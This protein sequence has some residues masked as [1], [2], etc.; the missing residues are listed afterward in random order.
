M[1]GI[2]NTRNASTPTPS[3][4]STRRIDMRRPMPSLSKRSITGSTRYAIR[5]AAASGVSAARSTKKSAS[6][7]A[8][9][10]R[11]VM[12]MRAARATK[13]RSA[14]A[15]D[16]SLAGGPGGNKPGGGPTREA[17]RR[18]DQREALQ[19][20]E[21]GAL[22]DGDGRERLAAERE[23]RGRPVMASGQDH[24]STAAPRQDGLAE[25]RVVAVQ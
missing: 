14:C 22:E 4:A 6:S 1:L 18:S 17:A 2:T 25:S 12:P 8:T 24:V 20:P 5:K 15:A 10:T 23:E 19:R 9:A 11:P 16:A 3:G 21:R 13:A 7:A